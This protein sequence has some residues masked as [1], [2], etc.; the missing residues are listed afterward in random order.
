MSLLLQYIGGPGQVEAFCRDRVIYGS[1]LYGTCCFPGM[2]VDGRF[3]KLCKRLVLQFVILKPIT[4]ALTLALYARNLYEK[5]D[6][7]L[8]ASCALSYLNV[9]SFGF[10]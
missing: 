6:W 9:A 10:L 7:R 1:C 3:V 2:Q 8:N 4:V 5:D